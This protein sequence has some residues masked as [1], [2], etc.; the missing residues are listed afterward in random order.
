[1]SDHT[2]KARLLDATLK[3]VRSKGYS[4]ARVEDV[5]AEAG[6]TK[7]SFFHHFKG[8][9]D[10]TLSAAALW[11]ERTGALFAQATYH[12]I[13]DPRDR[14][15][16]YVDMRREMLVG[17]LADFTCFAGTIVQEAYSTHPQIREACADSILGHART[18]EAD[19]SEAMQVY[20]VGQDWS[21]QSLARHT[22]AVIQGAF[23]IAKATG[24]AQAAAES[25]EHLRRYL[26]L[27][28][29]K[30]RRPR[31]ANRRGGQSSQAGT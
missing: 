23:I 3:V 11:D 6:L 5:C 12:R 1:M 15:L 14:L 28:F 24:D 21:A 16:A 29:V 22:Q 7:G 30:R 8:K 2:S 18:L 4:A 26:Q 17:E 31:R 25:L 19:I 20:E 9:E 13:S 10:L 27:L